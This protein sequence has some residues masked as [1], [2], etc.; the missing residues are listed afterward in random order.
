MQLEIK[1]NC[2]HQKIAHA[3][4]AEYICLIR[5]VWGSPFVWYCCWQFIVLKKYIGYNVIA[6]NYNM[7]TEDKQTCSYS[8]FHYT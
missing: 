8:L 6:L 5:Y 3:H 1:K 4:M 7:A 2:A